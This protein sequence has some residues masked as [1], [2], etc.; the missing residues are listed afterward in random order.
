MQSASTD[1]LQERLPGIFSRLQ[2]VSEEGKLK[3]W[4]TALST[5]FITVQGKTEES[6]DILR[7]SLTALHGAREAEKM[8]VTIAESWI[9]EGKAE[10]RAEGMAEGQAKS[11]LK[12]LKS[13]FGEVPAGI[14][15]KIMELR[16][17]GRVEEIFELAL[18][19]QSLDDMQ[20][21]L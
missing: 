4:S 3:S 19:C 13:R 2:N 21:A 10:G 11:A 20:K 1:Q 16:D 17:A 14:Q 18:T 15:K 8:T 6:V 9:A 12:V 7:Q 5:Y